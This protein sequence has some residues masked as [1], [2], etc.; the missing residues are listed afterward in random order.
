LRDQGKMAEAIAAFQ[1]AIR[2]K[3][4][5][6]EAHCNLGHVLSHQGQFRE[7]LAEVRRGHE[8]GSRQPGWSYASAEWVRQAERLVALEP[9]LPAVLGGDDK[10]KDA[11]EGIEFADMAYKTKQFGPSAR[12][13][14]ESLRTDP[15]LAEDMKAGHRYN[16]ACAAALAGAGQGAD[17]P[18]LAEK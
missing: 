14:A 18:P 11:A 16:A 15:K 3:P 4:D 9:R 8:L 6:A 17:M 13:Y 5:Y 10:P 12:L 2:L 1:K 7:A